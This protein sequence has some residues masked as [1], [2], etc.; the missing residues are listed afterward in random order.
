MLAKTP[1]IVSTD[2]KVIREELDA[3]LYEQF[4]GV[5]QSGPFIG[6][7]LMQ[8]T[9]WKEACISPML[10]GCYEK[11]LHGVLTQQITR[12]EKLEKPNIVVVGSAEGYYAIGLKRRLP[13][14]KVYAIDSD[15][16]ALEIMK[17]ASELNE[18]ELIVGADLGEVFALPDLIVMDCEGA[19]V[20][21]LNLAN[22]P[23]LAN[24]HMIVEI[25]NLAGQETDTIILERFRGTHQIDMLLEGSRNP[26]KYKELCGMS[27]DYRW[28]A[29]SE[30]RPCLMGWFSMTPRGMNL[31]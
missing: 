27:S 10:L 29:V 6:M 22:F 28:T 26:N 17:M 31:A 4:N 14:A 25:H 18:V 19:E 5:V 15:A 8:E 1:H 13:N 30:K 9:A 23:A 16:R 24:A 7:T 11:E 12:L 20:G 2:T 3:L 21:Y